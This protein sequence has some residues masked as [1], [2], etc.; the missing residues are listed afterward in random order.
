MLVCPPPRM[1]VLAQVIFGHPASGGQT[2][3][4][5]EA[6]ALAKTGVRSWLL[7]FDFER[8]EKD[9][10]NLS[11][12][13]REIEFRKKCL[14]KV[15]EASILLGDRA[16]QIYV[17]KNFGA[18]VGGMAASRENKI[19]RYI[20]IAGLPDLTNFYVSSD[21]PVALKARTQVSK[22]QLNRY[23]EMTRAWNPTQLLP[24]A[25]NREIFFQF[26]ARDPWIPKNIA[27]QF[28][29]AAKGSTAVQ[30]YD[31]D[32]DLKNQQAALDRVSFI[33]Q[34]ANLDT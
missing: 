29:H 27:E 25:K 20:L 7:D 21:H 8:N 1:D 18:F 24:T 16:P 4:F 15:Q 6:T 9:P 13:Q 31:D 11:N 30:Y 10:A 23:R 33:A 26:G 14:S 28:I 19:S 12:S 5:D 32:H 34:I 17:G 22:D 2:T 3:F